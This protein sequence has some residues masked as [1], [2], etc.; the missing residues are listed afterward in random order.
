M[1][2]I[3]TY[4]E[5]LKTEANEHL[6]NPAQSGENEDSRLFKIRQYKGTFDELKKYW[7]DRINQKH[8]SNPGR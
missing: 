6:S 3:K 8:H 4:K 5:Y 2:K 7:D 1:D